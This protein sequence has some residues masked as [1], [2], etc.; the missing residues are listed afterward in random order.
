M[1]AFAPLIGADRTS[2]RRVRGISIAEHLAGID[3]LLTA[4]AAYDAAVKHQ[5]K[6]KI[7]LR[8]GGHIVR[9]N[10]KD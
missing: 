1:S 3:D 10:V 6:E 9:R 7:T 4:L 5:P 8:R 2:I